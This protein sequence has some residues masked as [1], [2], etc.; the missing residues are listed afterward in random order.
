MRMPVDNGIFDR[1]ADGW[2]DAQGVL[3]ILRS[4]VNPVRLRYFKGVLADRLGVDLP[5]RTVVD[6]GCGGGCL[7]EEFARLGCWV[8]GVDPSHAS[9]DVA[10]RHARREGLDIAY[11][12]GAGEQLPFPDESFDLALCCDVL[13][14]VEDPARVLAEA[15]RVLRPGGVIL[16][17]TVNRTLPSRVMVGL[18]Q[19]WS[20]T[21][22]LPPRS[23]DWQMFIRPE[24]LHDLLALSGI[25]LADVVGAKPG[26]G[27]VSLVRA[28][29]QRKRG[30]LTVAQLGERLQFDPSPDTATLYMGYGMK[31]RRNRASD[32]TA[33]DR[34]LVGGAAVRGD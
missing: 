24:E 4:A 12:E 25:T 3:S 5:G 34:A 9:L 29:R 2:W 18:L 15:A 8:T 26:L 21:S 17:E 11:R 14:H 10:R 13:E 6:I 32:S 30:E 20:P 28:L 27:P 19:E 1:M 23:H 16:F 7:A 22:F 31:T 33:W